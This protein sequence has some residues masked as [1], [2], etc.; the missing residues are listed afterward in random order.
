MSK[1][2]I[3]LTTMTHNILIVEDQEDICQLIRVNLEL[4]NFKI[5]AT[6]DGLQGYNFALEQNFDLIILDIMLPSMDGLSICQALRSKGVN[7]PILMLTARKTETDRVAGL[8]IG[9]DDYLTKPFSVLELQA[10]TKA[11]LRRA[12]IALVPQ[13]QQ[14]QQLIFKNL[15]IDLLKRQ[16]EL[17]QVSLTLTAKEF[18][19]LHYLA[20]SPGQVFSREQLLNTVWGYDHSGYEH[21]V[22]SHINRLRAKLE[23]IP[24]K[25]EFI[26]TVW[27]VGY[28]F[29]DSKL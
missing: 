18:D 24:A 7:T 9:A 14:R 23:K 15:T 5:D 11:L 19:L 28:K 10:R 2:Y 8:N 27:G 26:V 13:Q 29:D 4:L 6:G 17:D 1:T 20:K 3:E 12:A 21:T 22:N 25:P 16:V